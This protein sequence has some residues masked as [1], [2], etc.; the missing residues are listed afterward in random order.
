MH[1]QL[2]LEGGHHW[3]F[4]M[5]TKILAKADYGGHKGA[6]SAVCCAFVKKVTHNHSVWTLDLCRLVWPVESCPDS[7]NKLML[8]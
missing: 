7:A 6:L 1:K 4:Q 5:R 2:A 3:C 8:S